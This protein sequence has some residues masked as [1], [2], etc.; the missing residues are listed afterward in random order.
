MFVAT[1]PIELLEL[2][3][4]ARLLEALFG[5]LT[6]FL[7]DALHHGAQIIHRNTH[8]VCTYCHG[9]DGAVVHKPGEE[10]CEWQMD[11]NTEPPQVNCDD[12]HTVEWV[13]DL[14]EECH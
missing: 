9:P 2:D 3:G 7:G 12:C 13:N 5:G 10:P 11:C 1:S 14:C 8:A 6:I 4:R